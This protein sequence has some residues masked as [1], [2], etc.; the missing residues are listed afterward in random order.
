ML[1]ER[2]RARRPFDPSIPGHAASS[3][4]RAAVA[5][6]GPIPSPGSR[7]AVPG[8]A[9]TPSRGVAVR[10]LNSAAHQGGSCV[11]ASGCS[12]SP[13]C[14]GLTSPPASAGGV[15]CDRAIA[16]EGSSFDPSLATT[17]VQDDLH[18]CWHNSDGFGH[19]ATAN[20][21]VFDT[22]V[23]AGD[24]D[25]DAQLFGSG[26]YL[27]HCEIHVHDRHVQRAT[28]RERR[29][30][31]AGGSFEL[32]VGDHGTFTPAPTWDVQRRRN[33]GAWVTIRTGT[34]LASFPIVLQRTGRSASGR[35]RT[36]RATSRGGRRRGSRR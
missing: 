22:G 19:T 10:T 3:T 17:V 31:R 12:R 24:G 11:D 28:G 16:I 29:R 36:C 9:P 32:R 20:S 30:D 23:I 6:S 25:A 5:T 14:L 4:R 27:Y 2:D 7:D 33:A 1:G 26:A 21:G 34:S 13:S 35:G 18:L 8:V 15:V